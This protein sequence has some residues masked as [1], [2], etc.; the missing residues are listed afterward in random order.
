MCDILFL[1][2]KNKP[3]LNRVTALKI[4]DLAMNYDNL[5]RKSS[6]SQAFISNFLRCEFQ[7]IERKKY[8]NSYNVLVICLRIVPFARQLIIPFKRFRIA[9][10]F[11]I[12]KRYTH[13]FVIEKRN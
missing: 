10:Q 7:V 5:L 6:I 3:H 11:D 4:Y 2:L 8:Y 12:F 1:L 13:L 9:L